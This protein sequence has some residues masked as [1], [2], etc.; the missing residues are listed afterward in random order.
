VFEWFNNLINDEDILRTTAIDIEAMA[1]IV[2]KTGAVL[3]SFRSAM[4][5]KKEIRKTVVDIGVLRYPEPGQPYF[6][7][8]VMSKPIV[9]PHSNLLA[10]L[11]DST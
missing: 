8:S 9:L 3:N 4:S 2:A 5:S 6:N 1:A 10:G 7:V 11:S